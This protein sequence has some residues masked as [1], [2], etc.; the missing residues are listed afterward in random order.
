M[1]QELDTAAPRVHTHWRVCLA[2]SLKD[3]LNKCIHAVITEH[4]FLFHILT[5]II[6]CLNKLFLFAFFFF[7]LSSSSVQWG[8]PL[9]A[10]AAVPPPFL[11]FLRF[12]F[13]LNFVQ[14]K[15]FFSSSF[16]SVLFGWYIVNLAEPNRFHQ[17]FINFDGR[18]VSLPEQCGRQKI[19]A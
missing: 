5:L 19:D 14:Q 3:D 1:E 15:L 13:F 9:V 6:Y 10:G 11:L 8:S 7:W 12:C 17:S 4:S 18:T 2:Q 16:S